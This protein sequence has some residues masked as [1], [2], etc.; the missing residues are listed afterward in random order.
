MNRAKVPAAGLG[1][2]LLLFAV[3]VAASYPWLPERLATHFAG[4]GRPDGWMPRSEHLAFLLFLGGGVP[5]FIVGL[6]YLLR[7]APT[8]G[9]N[10]ANRDYWL[11][12]E[13]RAVTF[14]RLL[15]AGFSIA[16]WCVGFAMGAHFLILAA[17]RQTPVR[18]SNG[19]TWGLA[20]V[21]LAGI[22]RILWRLERSFKRKGV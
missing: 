9:F 15:A 2:M 11:S 7:F 3:S 19:G 21:F 18:L 17:N 20:A 14:E 4:D 8:R 6:F 16:S 22:G 5:A 10:M 12:P 1:L 13:H